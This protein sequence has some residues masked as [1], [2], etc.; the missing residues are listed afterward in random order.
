VRRRAR[1][2]VNVHPGLQIEV[3]LMQR[4]ATLEDLEQLRVAYRALDKAGAI[5]ARERKAAGEQR[6]FGEAR[7]LAETKEMLWRSC[8]MGMVRVGQSFAAAGRPAL[9]RRGATHTRSD[10]RNAQVGR[11][12]DPPTLVGVGRRPLC[13]P[14]PQRYR[15]RWAQSAIIAPWS[16]ARPR[17]LK[18]GRGAAGS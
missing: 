1:I 12:Y 7:D 5:R 6:A 14:S 3:A 4:P 15:Q 9:Q 18:N 8:S 2:L 13:R 11:S 17:G 16:P 10:R